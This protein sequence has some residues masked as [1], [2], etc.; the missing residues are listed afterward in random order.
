MSFA[1]RC[2][3]VGEGA[4][5]CAPRTWKGRQSPP[6]LEHHPLGSHL[7]VHSGFS[8]PGSLRWKPYGELTGGGSVQDLLHFARK[9]LDPGK[10]QDVCGV[11]RWYREQEDSSPRWELGQAE[12]GVLKTRTIGLHLLEGHPLG[13][14]VDRSSGFSLRILYHLSSCKSLLHN[15]GT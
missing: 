11:G 5:I 13:S 7:A 4:V 15:T 8:W 2:Q 9:P 6:S 12:S 10:L 14:S 1:G 3:K